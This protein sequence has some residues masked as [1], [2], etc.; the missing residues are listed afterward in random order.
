MFDSIT[1]AN[2]DRLR[3]HPFIRRCRDGSITRHE[4]NVFL[5]Q[6]AKYSGYFTR[7]LC[8]LISNLH[9]NDD[10]LRLAENLAEE[11]GFGEHDSEPHARLFTRML[12]ELGVQQ[13]EVPT[14]PE[15]AHLIATALHYCKQRNPAYGLGALCLG[16][17]AI[18]APLYSDIIEGFMANGVARERLK[19]FE[20][21]VECDDDHAATMYD[22]LQRLQD[23]RPQDAA[24]MLEG[25][26]AMIDARLDFFNGILDGAQQACQ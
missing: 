23:Q 1:Q 13:H 8:A 18:V 12:A 6:Q 24:L 19:F 10:V 3:E 11:L 4:L 5:A 14:F 15:T 9:D 2:V 16:A 20:I 25:A 26:Q 7:Y 22:I 21:H 17:E